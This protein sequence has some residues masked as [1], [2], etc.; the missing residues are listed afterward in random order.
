[1]F[2]SCN[3]LFYKLQNLF[4]LLLD[5]LDHHSAGG[6]I[7]ILACQTLVVKQISRHQ[8]SFDQQGAAKY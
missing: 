1:M 8:N 4:T 5:E 3:L 7:Y 2:S 6:N